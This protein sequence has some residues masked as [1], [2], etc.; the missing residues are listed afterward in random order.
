MISASTHE[1]SFKYI[2]IGVA[3]GIGIDVFSGNPS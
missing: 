2:G 1:G 3:I